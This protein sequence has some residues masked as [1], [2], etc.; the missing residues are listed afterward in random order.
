[1]KY[2]YD[3]EESSQ[4]HYYATYRVKNT[5]VHVA[6]RPDYQGLQKNFR[7]AIEGYLS[8]TDRFVPHP[9][10]ANSAW[11]PWRESGGPSPEVLYGSL[12]TLNYWIDQL[13]LREIYI[14][15]DAG[16]H[17][18]PTIFGCY[19]DT[20]HATIARQV[21]A[22]VLLIGKTPTTHS[23]PL[24]YWDSYRKS[25]PELATLAYLILTARDSPEWGCES[26]DHI[27]DRWKALK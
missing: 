10:Y 21:A 2:W 19:L 8:V 23:C 7:N 20:Y 3:I 11:F 18:S 6:G 27:I 12:K 25:N 26:L 17:R 5:T 9:P 1:M 16:T 15:C 13:E 24:D 14:H 22:D 4:P